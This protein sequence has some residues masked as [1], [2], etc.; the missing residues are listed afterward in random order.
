MSRNFWFTVILLFLL[1]SVG[2][3]FLL[4]GG[5]SFFHS[6]R[7]TA[8]HYE[9]DTLAH[10]ILSQKEDVNDLIPSRFIDMKECNIG[11]VESDS[12]P[13]NA[14]ESQNSEDISDIVPC[15]C[16]INMTTSTERRE[17]MESEIKKMN[18]VGT[19]VY[20]FNAFVGE[21]G[22]I[23]CYLSH[24]CCLSWAISRDQH[25]L[26]L[27]D[28]FKL[29]DDS[30]T[31]KSKLRL[32]NNVSEGRWDCIVFGQYVQ[33]WQVYDDSSDVKVMRIYSSTTASGY[34][35]HRHYAR[36]FYDFLMDKA[37]VMLSNKKFKSE[38][39][40]DQVHRIIQSSDVWLGFECSI[41]G[42]RAGHSLIGDTYA[43]NT[44]K[45]DKDLRSFTNSNGATV[46]IILRPKFERKKVAILNIATNKYTC[47]VDRHH[48]E[49]NT[50]FLRAHHVEFFLFTDRT[51]EFPDNYTAYGDPLHV[52]HVDHE[53]WPMPTLKRFEFVMTQEEALK[54][55][56]YICYI[57]IDYG[58]HEPVNGEDIFSE[59]FTAVRHL[60][61]ITG[62]KV[63]DN[64]LG[65]PE[66][67]P[68]STACIYPHEKTV[69]YYVGGFYLG[70]KDAFLKAFREMKSMVQK[71]LDNNIIAKCHDESMLQRYLLDNPPARTLSQSYVYPEEC[72]DL[73]NRKGMCI[74]L[75][76]LNFKPIM[77]PLDKNHKEIRS[78]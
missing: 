43:D 42:Q 29:Y 14:F 67:R 1:A 65:S 77:C 30:I 26:I 48:R 58:I 46:P 35:V 69:A 59:G 53:P 75:R 32:A 55:F 28:D 19:E 15:I 25:V 21:N 31:M 60:T 4:T 9:P 24:L 18:L 62:V 51:S 5:D 2:T 78:S 13:T 63:D 27:E 72:F 20:R 34:L 7:L 68:E 10:F 57:D 70:T 41:G 64:R 49:C 74:A 39:C 73:S 6:S 3:F 44:W 36:R 71:D 33:D 56:D 47:F 22:A 23:G 66:I 38:Y 52:V 54:E 76:K 50:R 40:N 17:L 11:D 61:D 37:R 12:V 16:Y 45:C 8:R